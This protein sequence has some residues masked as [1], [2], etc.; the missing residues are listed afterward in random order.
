MNKIIGI[1]IGDIQGIGIRILIDRWKKNQINNFILFTDFNLINNI[2][3]QNKIHDKVNIINKYN[4]INFIKKKFNIFTYKSISLENN[5]YQ[6]LKYGYKFCKDNVCIGLITLPLRKDL[7]Q[8]NIDK[9]FI[10]QTE[11]FQKIDKKPYSNMILYHNKII[12]SPLTTHIKLKSVPK[13]IS[14]KKFIYNQIYNLYNTLIIDLNI[15]KPK[16]IISG[17]N[18]HAG[19]NGFLGNEEK[20]SLIPIIN[21]LKKRGIIIDGPLSADSILI[22]KNLKKYDCFVF[23]YHDQALIPFKYISQFSGVNYTG[24]L[25]IIRTSPDHGTAYNLVGK[26]NV[27]YTSLINCFKLIN[28]I[29]KNRT[30]NAKS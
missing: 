14:N 5:T 29:S 24:N 28:K 26:K 30:L 3:K 19:E 6:S 25:S 18:P 17:L 21:K 4:K 11:F 8:K 12:I 22:K 15:K 20:K 1:T 23:L 27:S 7:I 13:V 2:I 16:I 9:K 10:G